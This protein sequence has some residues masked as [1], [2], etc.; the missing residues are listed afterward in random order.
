MK[1]IKKKKLKK[2]GRGIIPVASIDPILRKMPDV[3]IKALASVL[4]QKRFKVVPV[5]TNVPHH[6][7]TIVHMIGTISIQLVPESSVCVYE[8]RKE[9]LSKRCGRG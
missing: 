4:F 2:K 3:I 5:L 1:E 6:M 8:R 7:T 9:T